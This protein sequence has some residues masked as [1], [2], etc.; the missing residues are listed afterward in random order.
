MGV[1]TSN[2]TDTHR[3]MSTHAHTT[4]TVA[5]GSTVRPAHSDPTSVTRTAAGKHVYI[6]Q[7]STC[8]DCTFWGMWLGFCI[9]KQKQKQQYSPF[10]SM[11]MSFWPFF[12][13]FR[14]ILQSLMGKHRSLNGYLLLFFPSALH[15]HTRFTPTF[16]ICKNPAVLH[17]FVL[18]VCWSAHFLEWGLSI[19][20]S[21]DR[22]S[23]LY[24]FERGPLWQN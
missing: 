13:L 15:V 10:T 9:D 24:H 21:T 20:Q 1:R 7:M 12:Q 8:W 22:G 4:E 3:N 14:H 11:S 16:S 2:G 17:F 18:L 19:G 23:Q 6:L 5:G